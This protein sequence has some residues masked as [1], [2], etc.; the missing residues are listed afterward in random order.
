MGYGEFAGEIKSGRFFAVGLAECRLCPD[1]C[2]SELATFVRCQRTA[3]PSVGLKPSVGMTNNNGLRRHTSLRALNQ[4]L[5]K[6][7]HLGLTAFARFRFPALSWMVCFEPVWPTNALL[8]I[9][10]LKAR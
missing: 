8:S 7:H 6:L 3:D 4:R 2:P 9:R 1:L 5:A 10:R